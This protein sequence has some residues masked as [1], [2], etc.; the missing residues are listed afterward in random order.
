[1]ARNEKREKNGY[2]GMKMTKV[3]NTDSISEE[4]EATQEFQLRTLHKRT[5]LKCKMNAR[6]SPR[7]DMQVAHVKVQG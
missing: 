7:G 1:M 6:Q 4:V 3:N 5:A 2:E